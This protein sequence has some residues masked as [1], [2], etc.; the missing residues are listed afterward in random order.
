MARSPITRG[1][2]FLLLAGIGSI[3]EGVGNLIEDVFGIEAAVWAFFGGGVL[4]VTSLVVA[5]VAALTVVSPDRWSGLFLLLGVPA[6]MLGFG[7]AITGISWIL[8]G[9]WILTR[10]RYLVPAMA[11]AAVPLIAAGAYVNL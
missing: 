3:T 2:V 4:Y 9:L 10:R 6:A 11:I 1:A 5:G 8:F 7:W